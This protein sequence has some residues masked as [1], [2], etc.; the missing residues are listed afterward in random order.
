M[1][2]PSTKKPCTRSAERT[3]EVDLRA[4]GKTHLRR[5]ESSLEGDDDGLELVRPD[6]EDARR[7]R[8]PRRFA[9]RS[10]AVRRRAA[11]DEEEHGR[12]ESR[13]P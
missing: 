7:V 12:E 1:P 3:R 8:I 5:I 13:G 4:H 9:G 11:P 6:L 2:V 10:G